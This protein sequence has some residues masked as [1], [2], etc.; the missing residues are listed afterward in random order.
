MDVCL[1]FN[2]ELSTGTE[3][4]P[5][6]KHD[7]L[8]TVAEADAKGLISRPF[9]NLEHPDELDGGIC[10]CCPECCYYFRHPEEHCDKGSLCES[11]LA[12]SCTGCLLCVESCHFGARRAADGRL[13]VDRDKCYGCGL[14]VGA[15]P[16]GC[17][18]MK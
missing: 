10:F 11:T 17:I 6:S 14:C 15:C 1:I 12:G 8:E 13:V 3:R 2:P 7:A 4:R 18:E 9:R 16:A 5:A